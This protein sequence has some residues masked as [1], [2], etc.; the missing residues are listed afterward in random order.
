MIPLIQW[1]RLS[2]QPWKNEKIPVKWDFS[3]FEV[4]PDLWSWLVIAI[5][6]QFH[7]RCS[8]TNVPRNANTRRVS[9][10]LF[11]FF[12]GNTHLSASI[13][14]L[15]TNSALHPLYRAFRT[16][17]IV[18]SSASGNGRYY[19]QVLALKMVYTYWLFS[20]CHRA[21]YGRLTRKHERKNPP[22]IPTGKWWYYVSRVICVSKNNRC[23]RPVYRRS[24]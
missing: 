5:L 23:N 17:S 9:E 4:S 21:W 20:I 10:Y 6:I 13:V 12:K 3:C 14:Y 24:V 15:C 16:A 2:F 18:F 19:P 7:D 11:L 1:N 22:V 8:R